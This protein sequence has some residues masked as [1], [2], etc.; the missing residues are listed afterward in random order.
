MLE[1]KVRVN[2]EDVKSGKDGR[3]GCEEGATGALRGW[4]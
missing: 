3:E 4:Q 2:D 1:A